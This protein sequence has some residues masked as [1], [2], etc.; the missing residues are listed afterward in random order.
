MFDREMGAEQSQPRENVASWAG[1]LL[2]RFLAITIMVGV[3]V[4]LTAVPALVGLERVNSLAAAFGALAI[5][6]ILLPILDLD[7]DDDEEALLN[8]QLQNVFEAPLAQKFLYVSSYL[9]VLVTAM[10]TLVAATGLAAWALVELTGIGLL[11]VLLAVVYPGIDAYAGR[12]AGWNI[13]STGGIV[14][15]AVL[16]LVA[17]MYRSQTS[18]PK[19]AATD[20]RQFLL[21]H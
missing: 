8:S 10:S 19:Q 17:F 18:I 15:A 1:T 9:L 2:G 11:G 6:G 3:L 14:A 13:A 5:V 4:S 16:Y 21:A 20:A 7:F 12:K